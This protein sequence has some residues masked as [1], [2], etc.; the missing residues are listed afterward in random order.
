MGKS[1]AQRMRE[2]VRDLQSEEFSH[3]QKMYIWDEL[4][5]VSAPCL[6]LYCGVY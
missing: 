5:L 2:C 4:E 6:Y 3:E 1:D